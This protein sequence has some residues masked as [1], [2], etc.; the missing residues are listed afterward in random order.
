MLLDKYMYAA[1][2][3]SILLEVHA[4]NSSNNLKD[5]LIRY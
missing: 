4:E 1:S 5:F 2:K 3:R